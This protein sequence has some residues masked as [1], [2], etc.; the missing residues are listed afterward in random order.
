[1][2]TRFHSLE[3]PAFQRKTNNVRWTQFY[4]R[5]FPLHYDKI[6]RNF[7][8]PRPSHRAWFYGIPFDSV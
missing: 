4:Q 1:M 7:R 2:K 8:R 3:F 6:V 5:H